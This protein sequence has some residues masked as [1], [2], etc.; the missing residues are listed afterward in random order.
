M[1]QVDLLI[2]VLL[3]SI[4]CVNG[5]DY[6]TVRSGR[7]AY[8]NNDQGMVKCIRIDSVKFDTDSILYPMPNIQQLD[9]NCFTPKGNSWIGE[10]VIIQGNGVNLFFNSYGD[11]L[12]INTLAK[13]GDS[14]TLYEIKDSIKVTAEVLSAQM[15][16]I[17]G[18]TDSV[19]TIRLKVYIKNWLATNHPLTGKTLVLSK[20]NG[21][22]KMMNFNEFPEDREFTYNEDLESLSLIGLTNPDRGVQNLT[23][24]GVNDYQVGDELHLLYNSWDW[25]NVPGHSYTRKTKLKYLERKES[26]DTVFYKVEKEESILRRI[27]KWDSTSYSYTH[28]TITKVYIPDTLFDKLPEE[29]IISEYRAYAYTMINEDQTIRKYYSGPIIVPLTKHTCWHNLIYEGG[30]FGYYL[31]GLGGP[32]YEYSD[33]ISGE[34]ESPVYYKK[35]ATTW[36]TPLVITGAHSLEIEDQVKIYPNPAYDFIMLENPTGREEKYVLQLIDMQGREVLKNSITLSSSYKV[37]LSSLTEGAY[38]LKLQNGGKQISRL[39]IK[40]P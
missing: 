18:E 9:Y 4:F 27:G 28:D 5:Q 14:W 8:F 16:A 3:I 32:Y 35:G 30:G 23:W 10:K 39:I 24:L 36:G 6:Q 20:N 11:T 29:P 2:S 38:L 37:D 40:K 21:L 26:K 19:K 12:R 1:K 13:K 17:L 7:I 33:F 22:V 15:M 31:K 34:D 25:N